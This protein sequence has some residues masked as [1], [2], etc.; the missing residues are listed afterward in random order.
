MDK[1]SNKDC[2]INNNIKLKVFLIFMF[3]DRLFIF[4]K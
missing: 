4:E 3:L 2:N 1:K